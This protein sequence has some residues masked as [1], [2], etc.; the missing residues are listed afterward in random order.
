ML[1][2]STPT[3]TVDTQWVEWTGIYTPSAADIGSQFLFTA[4]FDLDAMHAIAIDGSVA[5]S[6][7]PAQGAF[8]GGSTDAFAAKVDPAGDPVYSTFLGGNGT[9]RG[10]G[11]AVDGF[12]NA[13]VTG[14]TDSTTGFPTVGPIQSTNNGSE[15]AF[16][17]KVSADAIHAGRSIKQITGQFT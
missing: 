17:T 12:G 1:W 10:F 9:D 5:L 11:I 6:V 3:P 15:D 2:T 16:V 13:Y 8:G 14:R 7:L 4:I